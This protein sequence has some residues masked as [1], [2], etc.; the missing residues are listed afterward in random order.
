MPSLP[1][2]KIY[3]VENSV[4]SFL[5]PLS[6]VDEVTIPFCH[7]VPSFSMFLDGTEIELFYIHSRHSCMMV[8]SIHEAWGSQLPSLSLSE[9]STPCFRGKHCRDLV[10][11]SLL[12][13]KWVGQAHTRRSLAWVVL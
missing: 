6:F 4:I 8:R 1:F 7:I 5:S 3:L 9:H 10:I 11:H 13:V 12:N 2:V